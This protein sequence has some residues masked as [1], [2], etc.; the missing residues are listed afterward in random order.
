M[1]VRAATRLEAAAYEGETEMGQDIYK[2]AVAF[3]SAI[4]E[5]GLCK[6]VRQGGR[7]GLSRLTNS[8]FDKTGI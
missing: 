5:Q 6:D 8:Y 1:A 4:N 2:A 7:W 3:W